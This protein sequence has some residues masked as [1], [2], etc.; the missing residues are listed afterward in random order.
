MNPL[1]RGTD[2]TKCFAC[3]KILT[4]ARQ[5]VRAETSDGQRVLVGRECFRKIKDAG[6]QGYQPPLG[7]PKL[8]PLKETT[9]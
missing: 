5:Y 4:G 9:E 1:R 3:D 8:F 6:D 2:T 7:G